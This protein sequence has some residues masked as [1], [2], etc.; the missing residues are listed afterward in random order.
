MT[1]LFIVEN[2]RK[3]PFDFPGTQLVTPQAYLTQ[4]QFVDLKRAR[5]YNMCRSNGYQTVGYY[6]SLLAAARGHRPL[7][8]VTTLQD[9]K[10]GSVVRV[11]AAEL[12]GGVRK[13]LDPIKSDRFELSIYFGRNLAKRYDRL[14]Q[15]IF[16][17]FPAPLL[18]AE[19]RN[20]DGWRLTGVRPIAPMDIPDSHREFVFEQARRFFSRPLLASKPNLRYSLAILVDPEERDAPSNEKALARFER[21]AVRFGLQPSRIDKDD[22]G[23]IAEFDALF[24]RATTQVNHYTYRFARRAAAEGLVVIDDPDSI[25]RCTNKVYQA[26]LFRRHGLPTPKTLVVHRGNV[27]RIAEQLGFPCVV[28]QPDSAFSAGVLK[29]KTPAELDQIL[30]AMLTESELAV[31][32]SYCPSAFDWRV[33]VLDQ[34][35]LYVCRYHMARGHWQIQHTPGGKRQVYGRSETLP[36]DAAPPEVLRLGVQAAGLFGNSFYGVDIK[37][38]D[39]KLMV[40]EVNDNPSVDAGCEDLVLKD[41]LYDAIMRSIA[42][43]IESR[44]ASGNGRKPDPS[45]TQEGAAR[46]RA[47]PSQS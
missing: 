36:L 25:V 20:Q 35:A 5:V 6:V 31:A 9:L 45:S 18:R 14:A 23:R 43:R 27:D 19:F 38:V 17:R 24:I 40:I 13:L 28:K 15:A 8:S 33:G 3:W 29:A 39:G 12:E 37:E 44:G 10:L 41:E 11:A 30:S 2:P 16:N 1:T 32:Q 47:N 42:S 26:E 46:L 21:A 34:K 22:F 4:E 7:P